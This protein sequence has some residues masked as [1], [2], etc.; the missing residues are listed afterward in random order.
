M[1][2]PKIPATVRQVRAR[3]ALIEKMTGDDEGAHA[4]E[5]ELYAD[6]LTAIATD[7]ALDPKEMARAALKT[8]GIHFGR[9]YA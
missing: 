9:W 7:V 1:S 2:A 8:S 3:V 5:D 6:V 4:A